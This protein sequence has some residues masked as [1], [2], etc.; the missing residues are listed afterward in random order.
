MLESL[1]KLFGGSTT[2]NSQQ[3]AHDRLK[4]VLMHDRANISPEIMEKIKND[5]MQ[6]ISRYI[7]IDQRGMDVS[8]EDD[9]SG[10]VALIANIPVNGMRGRL[11]MQH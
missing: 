9:A 10:A 5:I 6:V 11:S 1:L 8:L 3:I 2:K 7:D 4:L